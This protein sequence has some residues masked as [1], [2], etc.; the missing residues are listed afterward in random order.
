MQSAHVLACGVAE[1]ALEPAQHRT[2]HFAVAVFESVLPVELLRL[3]V[4]ATEDAH[5]RLLHARLVAEDSDRCDLRVR[6]RGARV[7]LL[8]LL[9][10]RRARASVVPDADAET[11]TARLQDAHAVAVPEMV[12]RLPQAG[13]FIEDG[14]RRMS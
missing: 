9:L 6:V 2:L 11:S 4:L 12:C 10:T 14:A 8:L 3:A 7:G 1:R 5:D 13:R